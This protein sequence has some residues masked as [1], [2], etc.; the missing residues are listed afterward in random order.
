MS[1]S[2]DNGGCKWRQ[3]VAS[4]KVPDELKECL[5]GYR[6]K[7]ILVSQAEQ[8][9]EIYFQCLHEPDDK[10]RDSIAKVWSDHFGDTYRPVLHFETKKNY[11]DLES[12]SRQ[13]WPEIVEKLAAELPSCRGWLHGAECS[14][15]KDHLQ[16]GI[17][18]EI[19]W[20][21]LMAQ[22][23][24]DRLEKLFKEEYNL[25]VTVSIVLK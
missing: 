19:G 21:Y 13:L 24:K 9:W 16:I 23:V 17:E 15:T 12:L 2:L 8:A 3:L 6:L 5:S 14:V 7:K 4:S 22:G 20:S 18:Q 10:V 11:D 1:L 25:T